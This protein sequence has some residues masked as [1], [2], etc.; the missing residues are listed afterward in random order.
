MNLWFLRLYILLLLS[1]I[2]IAL[3]DL[4]WKIDADMYSVLPNGHILKDIG[5]AEQKWSKNISANF[6]ILLSG[7]DFDKAK[8]SAFLLY[9]KFAKDSSLEKFE[10]FADS[11]AVQDLRNFFFENKMRL[12]TKEFVQILNTNTSKI[13]EQAF[14]KIYGANPLISLEHLDEDPFLLG[15]NGME[16]IMSNQAIGTWEIRDNLR[17]AKDNSGNSYIL[18]NGKLAKDVS[19]IASKKNIISRIKEYVK[20]QN[21]HIAFSGIPFHI[22]ESSGN[23]QREVAAITVL[24]MLSVILLLLF[25]FR[26]GIPLIAAVGVTLISVLFAASAVQIIF[27]R[28]HIFTFVFGTSIIGLSLDYSIHFFSHWKVAAAN[29]NGFSIRSKIILCLFFGFLTTQ[30]GYVALMLTRFPLLVQIAAFS[31]FG[32]MCAFLSVNILFPYFKL[33]PQNKRTLHIAFVARFF[34]AAKEYFSG[35][36]I[37]RT[38]VLAV[39][40]STF[41]FGLMNFKIENN[42][43]DFYSMSKEMQSYEKLSAEIMNAGTGLFYM[44]WGSSPE[45]VLENEEELRSHLDTLS[46]YLAV[47]TFVPSAKTQA[48]VYNS[49]N[50]HLLPLYEEQSMMLGLTIKPQKEENN[51]LDLNSKF[52]EVIQ[53]TIDKLWLGKIG[54]KYYSAVLILKVKDKDYLKKIQVKNAILVDKVSEIGNELTVISKKIILMMLVAYAISLL[55][56]SIAYKFKEALKI[57]IVP[58]LASVISASAMSLLG[59]SMSFFAISGTILTLAIGIDYS[60]FFSKGNGDGKITFFAVFLS[61]LST[62]L[63]FGLLSLSN[64]APVSHLGLSVSIGV[65]SCFLLSFFLFSRYER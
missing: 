21:L 25:A 65:T 59:F 7:K 64:F 1:V 11:N 27:D 57:L 10:I 35:N 12:Q 3:T 63:S 17:V 5:E 46:S 16:L 60:I 55:L 51:I 8:E 36:K 2:G 32:L 4:P 61:M 40:T 13:Q 38:A 54:D 49:I 62:V 15:E 23:A 20:E 28:I 48:E 43:K 22:N 56:L 41:V 39:L 30:L 29:E 9:N 19:P 58:L 26:S 31:F 34:L 52:P 45:E 6:M 47:S 37:V 53:Q 18:I 42:L 44:V 33:P 50:K 14:S 24:S